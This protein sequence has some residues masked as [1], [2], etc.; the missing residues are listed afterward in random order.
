MAPSLQGC[1]KDERHNPQKAL[2]TEPGV[3]HMLSEQQLV[4]SSGRIQEQKARDC[5]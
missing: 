3:Q 2:G 4:L 1:Y 5:R